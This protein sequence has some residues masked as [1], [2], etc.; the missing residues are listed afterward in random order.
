MSEGA[1]EAAADAGFAKVRA[2]YEGRGQTYG[3]T[4][5][6]VPDLYDEDMR[7]GDAWSL[8]RVKML[9]ALY[10]RGGHRDSLV[11]LVAYACAYLQ[12]MDEAGEEW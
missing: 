10:T 3:S 9:R 4:W 11:D 8:I 1:F 7:L 5:S 2:T 12:W 6:I